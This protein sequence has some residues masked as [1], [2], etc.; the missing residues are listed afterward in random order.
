MLET[1]APNQPLNDPCIMAVREDWIDWLLNTPRGRANAALI[2]ASPDL[3]A[4][5]EAVVAAWDGMDSQTLGSAIAEARAVLANA[6]G[7]VQHA[8]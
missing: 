5:C 6:E 4:A 7:K 2:E 1:Q 8:P 3:L